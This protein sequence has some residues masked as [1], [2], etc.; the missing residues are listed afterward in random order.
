MPRAAHPRILIVEDDARYVRLPH[1]I[2]KQRSYRTL[3]A[4]T[5]ALSLELI[6]SETP[7]AV[8]LDLG[9]P[10]IDS[11]EVL[12]RT[13]QFTDV[14]V[15]VISARGDEAG[16]VRGQHRLSPARLAS[17]GV[18]FGPGAA[19]RRRG[20]ES[21]QHTRPTRSRLGRHSLDLPRAPHP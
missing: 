3:S 19:A 8:L 12:R 13:R 4:G 17:R 14:P 11:L 18:R 2:L 21:I 9:L 10:D 15:I 20:G 7:D 16:V 1:A 5:G 6:A